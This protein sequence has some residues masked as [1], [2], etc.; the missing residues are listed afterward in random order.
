FLGRLF[1]LGGSQSEP[2]RTPVPAPTLSTEPST[3]YVAPHPGPGGPSTGVPT[4]AL[5][6]PPGAGVA[7]SLP[8]TSPSADDGSTRP[9]RPQP[10]VSRAATEADPIL[11]RVALGRA[12]D[13]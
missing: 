4:P 2:Q 1:R 13:G 12:D 9:I 3:G 6:P 7:G 8:S 5:L 11:T 10:R